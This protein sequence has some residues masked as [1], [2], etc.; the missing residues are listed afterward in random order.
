MGI[1]GR[2]AGEEF[3]MMKKI[4]KVG[5]VPGAFDLFHM[6]HLNLLRKA[7][8]RCEYLIAGIVT[9][10]LLVSY[11]KKNPYIPFEERFAIVEAIKYVDKAVEVSFHNTGKFDAWKL[12]QYDCH[13]AG[14]DHAGHWPEE[15]KRLQEAGSNMEFFPYTESITSTQIRKLI[16]KSLL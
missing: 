2:G 3:F 4:Y 1:S 7:K 10:E 12:Y 5:Y 13:F 16:D 15:L 11:K 6:G 9:D 8:E 14:S